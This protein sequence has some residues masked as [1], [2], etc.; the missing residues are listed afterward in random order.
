MNIEID[1]EVFKELTR[2]RST[3]DVSYND[4]LREVLGMKP[5][6]RPQGGRETSTASDWVVKG[7]HFPVGS[8]FRATYRGTGYSGRV[9]SSGLVIGHKQFNSPSA[10]AVS[11]TGSPVNGWN[12]WEC[13]MP[14]ETSWQPIRFFRSRR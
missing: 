3:E 7:V 10:A 4:V 9:E 12:F 2:R 13:R 1:F 5:A 14:G 8:E 6:A 11:I